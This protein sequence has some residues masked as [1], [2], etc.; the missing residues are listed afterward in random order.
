MLFIQFFKCEV[1]H[2]VFGFIR[3][4]EFDFIVLVRIT[5]GINDHLAVIH[6]G[7]ATHTYAG[8]QMID[9]F[10]FYYAFLPAAAKIKIACGMK[11]GDQVCCKFFC[12]GN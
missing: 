10:Y 12:Q 11:Q 8:K 4:A 7:F 6:D 3:F 5:A 2:P 9:L 1:S